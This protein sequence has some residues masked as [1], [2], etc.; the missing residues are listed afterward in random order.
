MWGRTEQ[1]RTCILLFAAPDASGFFI[2][3]L[4]TD[5]IAQ[6]LKFYNMNSLF[7]RVMT[8]EEPVISNKPKVDPRACGVPKG[9]PPLNHFLGIPFFNHS[10]DSESRVMVGMVGIANKPGGYSEADIAFLEPFSI[11]CCNLIQAYAAIQENK[12]LITTLEER[13]AERTNEL[14]LANENLEEANRKVVKASAAQLTHFAC[15]SHEI[16]TPLNCIVGLSVSCIPPY[17]QCISKL[18]VTC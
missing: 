12:H 15:M 6:G 4:I 10:E 17:T 7:G 1:G 2:N 9:H 11:T 3:S 8:S 14:K 5:N 18:F 16:R 13:V